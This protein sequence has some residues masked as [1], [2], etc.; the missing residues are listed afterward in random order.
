MYA[1]SSTFAAIFNSATHMARPGGVD[2]DRAVECWGFL[3]AYEHVPLELSG[4]VD[5]GNNLYFFRIDW[6]ENMNY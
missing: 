6:F 2:W 3:L 4:G 5:R 1:F